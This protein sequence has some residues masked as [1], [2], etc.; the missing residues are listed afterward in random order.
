MDEAALD[1]PALVKRLALVAR[2]TGPDTLVALG[3]SEPIAERLAR[4]ANL[5]RDRVNGCPLQG[6][7][8]LVLEDHPHRTGADLRRIRGCALRHRSILSRVEASNK[9]A[10]GHLGAVTPS[11]RSAALH[12]S[13]RIM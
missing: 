1:G 3:L 8:A 5:G 9:P 11:W 10:A 6:M 13:Y 2:L 4:A 12:L 7:L